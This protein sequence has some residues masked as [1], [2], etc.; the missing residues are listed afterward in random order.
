MASVAFT[1]AVTLSWFAVT[2]TLSNWSNGTFLLRFGSP[3]AHLTVRFV[4]A[5][6]L[7]TVATRLPLA[8]LRLLLRVYRVPALCLMIANAANSVALLNCGVTLT[9]VVK[10]LI[11]VF[12]ALHE[13]IL[14]GR[15][16]SVL[17]YASLVPTVV[18][19]SLAS[20]AEG[21]ELSAVGLCAALT[22]AVAQTALN[23]SSKTAASTSGAKPGEAFYA[24]TV[25]CAGM[26]L[27][28]YLPW[29][30][31]SASLGWESQVGHVDIPGYQ[32]TTWSLCIIV[33]TAVAFF[34]E[35]SLNFVFV[36]LVT[37]LSFSIGD[38]A[39]RL[40]TIAMGALIF[41]KPLTALN[42]SG[43]LLASAGVAAYTILQQRKPPIEEHVSKLDEAEKEAQVS[44]P[45][46]EAAAR[47]LSS[48]TLGGPLRERASKTL[49]GN[50]MAFAKRRAPS[51]M[52]DD[53]ASTENI[54]LTRS[55]EV[56][57]SA[58]IDSKMRPPPTGLAA[59]AKARLIALGG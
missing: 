27:S 28:S 50:A 53:G 40:T 17:E 22:S 49:I 34:V 9:Y 5:A 12:T 4:G 13:V 51:K 42:A 46:K 23:I 58:E 20:A 15:Q 48:T 41:N 52:F 26:S 56:I 24:L 35:Y 55:K 33:S 59:D 54:P 2:A 30:A 47:P 18:G 3:L 57:G 7:S 38:I 32:G 31:A 1:A 8:R 14:H 11:P 10:A 19:V 37:P 6:L 43:A 21:A 29:L 44:K 39:R 16:F 25:I 36:V 45:P